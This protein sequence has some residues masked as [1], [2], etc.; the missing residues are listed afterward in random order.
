M[1]HYQ[2]YMLEKDYNWSV[3]FMLYNFDCHVFDMVT[4]YD[5]R[6]HITNLRILAFIHES[7]YEGVDRAR[8]KEIAIGM[9]QKFVGPKAQV[10]APWISAFWGG[11]VERIGFHFDEP[12]SYEELFDALAEEMRTDEGYHDLVDPI[13][14]S[15]G[16][17][18]TGLIAKVSKVIA[19]PG[20][21]LTLESLFCDRTIERWPGTLAGS[22]M[23]IIGRLHQLHGFQVADPLPALTHHELNPA[24]RFHYTMITGWYAHRNTTISSHDVRE[25]LTGVAPLVV[26]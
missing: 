2:L 21:G 5:T 6:A 16:R 3:G 22:M 20:S 24:D 12:W 1:S 23:R 7:T 8:R 26:V 25:Y 17:L 4:V 18:I 14:A 19:P 10:T 9:I 13:I 11:I 15:A